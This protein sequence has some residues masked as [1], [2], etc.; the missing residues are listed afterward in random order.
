MSRLIKTLVAVATVFA[1][2]ASASAAPTVIKFGL[3]DTG[4]DL[5]H[6]GS[7]FETLD[8][9]NAATTGD[10]DT[11]VDY[12]GPLGFL[13]DL[14]N[15]SFS[16]DAVTLSGLANVLS[17]GFFAQS[18]TGGAFSFFGPANELLLSGTIGNG[19]LS[20]VIGSSVGSWLSASVTFVGGI[21][22]PYL[23][24][25]S[26]AI[27]ISLTDV[28]SNGVSGFS[29]SRCDQVT[30]GQVCTLDNFTADATGNVEGAAVPEPATMGL[31]GLGLLGAGAARRR[32][33]A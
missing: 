16:L 4:P 27:S 19:T 9:G 11:N 10:Q 21:V 5:V 29:V 2:V 7:S 32:K 6:F 20:G 15:A 1:F 25:N 3:G 13:A 24:S 17:G 31:L 18:T 28:E 12:V 14:A 33:S 26:G 22:A 23:Q 30:F 8:D